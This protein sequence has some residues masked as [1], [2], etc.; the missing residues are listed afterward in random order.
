M[1]L[2][3]NQQLPWEPVYFGDEEQIPVLQNLIAQIMSARALT[4]RVGGYTTGQPSYQAPNFSLS[5]YSP[6]FGFVPPRQL[7]SL[8]S[9][10]VSS[11]GP[12]PYFG[13]SGPY[14]YAATPLIGGPTV[15]VAIAQMVKELGVP[16]PTVQKSPILQSL[17]EI[18]KT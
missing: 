17:E 6:S 18:N 14:Q 9:S 13:T 5:S 3:G 15:D 10:Y 12:L 1:A 16:P 11:P 8:L 4:N 2:F 7:P